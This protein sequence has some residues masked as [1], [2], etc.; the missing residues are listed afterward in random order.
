[1]SLQAPPL[2]QGLDSHSLSFT[3]QLAPLHP[4]SQSHLYLQWGPWGSS[5]TPTLP[6]LTPFYSLTAEGLVHGPL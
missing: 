5:R 2:A 4:G 1:M 6:A 3:S